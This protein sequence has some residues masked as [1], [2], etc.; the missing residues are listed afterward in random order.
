MKY[1]TQEIM[2]NIKWKERM[3]QQQ[4]KQKAHRRKKHEA[5]QQSRQPTGWFCLN[6]SIDVRTGG[7]LHPVEVMMKRNAVNETRMQ[8][9][10]CRTNAHTRS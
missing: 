6:T 1:M 8:E 5:Q 4:Q 7:R 9:S 10:D 3:P 2:Q